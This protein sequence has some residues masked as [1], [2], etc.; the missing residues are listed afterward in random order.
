M[1]EPPVDKLIE[2]A[3]CR[4]ELAC[5]IS[6]R[7]KELLALEVGTLEKAN[8]KAVSYAAKE[9]YEGKIRIVH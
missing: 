7:S 1:I 3:D 6:K 9:F 2:K 8:L 5:A 4:F